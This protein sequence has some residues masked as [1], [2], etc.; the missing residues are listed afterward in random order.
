MTLER[1]IILQLRREGYLDNEI[2]AICQNEIMGLDK[3]RI[4]EELESP[5]N[6][7]TKKVLVKKPIYVCKDAPKYLRLYS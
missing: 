7:L 1:N 3:N 2:M 5:D 6:R 4:Q